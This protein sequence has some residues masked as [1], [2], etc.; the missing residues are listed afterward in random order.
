MATRGHCVHCPMA[1]PAPALPPELSAW[2]SQ[3]GWSL[4]RHQAEMLEIAT[5]GRHALLVADTGAGKT[6]GGFLP[7]LAEFCPSQGAVPGEG[8]HTLYVSPL[9]AFA[10]DVQRNLLAPIEELGLA[11][12]VEVRSGD[13]PS[14]RKARQRSRPPQVLLTTPESLSLLLSYSEAPTLFAGLKRV[15]IDEVHA[16]APTKRGHLLAL[17]LA[18]LQTLAP[19]MQ[20]VALSATL[21]EPEEFRAWLAPGGQA[22]SVDLVIGETGAPAELE[23]LLPEEA[24]IPWSGHAA[25]WAVPQLIEKLKPS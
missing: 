21:A 15:V 13:T 18:R 8:L 24:R 2:F 16:L 10:H 7:T 22:D 20:R 19:A 11:L 4:R 17:G 1:M 9:K 14:D 6:L 23:I 5:S 3:R 25:A 12:R